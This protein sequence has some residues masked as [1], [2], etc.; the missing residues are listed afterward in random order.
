MY[1]CPAWECKLR[2]W[3]EPVRES[4]LLVSLPASGQIRTYSHSADSVER[5]RVD[6]EETLLGKCS[7][8]T[9]IEYIGQ[10]PSYP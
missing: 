1:A 5:Y 3:T 4:R 7:T 10:S 9:G 8:V 2:Q 6:A